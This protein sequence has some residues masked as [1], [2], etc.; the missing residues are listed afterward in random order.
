MTLRTSTSARL[1]L[2][3]V[4]LALLAAVSPVRGQDRLPAMPGYDQYEQMRPEI[5]GSVTS[6][7]LRVSWEEDG[8]AFTYNR[9]WRA[10]R[11]RIA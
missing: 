5:P 4:T 3:C 1:R 11:D 2:A 10:S 9:E 6:G 7:A 8:A